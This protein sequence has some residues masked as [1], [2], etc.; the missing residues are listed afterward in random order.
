MLNIFSKYHFQPAFCYHF[1]V[2]VL[3]IQ[4]PVLFATSVL[5]NIRYGRP[6]ATDDEV[7][8]T[9]NTLCH[10]HCLMNSSIFCYIISF[11]FLP[12]MKVL[13]AAQQ[14]NADGFIRDFPEVTDCTVYF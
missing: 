10:D 5:E 7:Y 14:A 1:Y 3:Y 6:E 12:N 9:D 4:E 13:A 2:F 11:D 8:I